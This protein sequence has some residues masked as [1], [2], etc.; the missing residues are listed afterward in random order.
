MHSAASYAQQQ[1]NISADLTLCSCLS[2]R[3]DCGDLSSSINGRARKALDSWYLRDSMAAHKQFAAVTAAV[4]YACCALGKQY[5][6]VNAVVHA[7]TRAPRE[8]VLDL[9]LTA[10]A[11]CLRT[12]R[13]RLKGQHLHQACTYRCRSRSREAPSC[14]AV[15]DRKRGRDHYKTRCSR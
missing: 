13:Q 9:W 11:S 15:P 2:N 12:S 14:P 3:V 4:A 8:V 10:P 1:R 5:T 6:A 7:Q